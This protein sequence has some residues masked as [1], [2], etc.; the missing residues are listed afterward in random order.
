MD[1]NFKSTK[2]SKIVMKYEP[3]GVK[4]SDPKAFE[5]YLKKV[6]DFIQVDDKAKPRVL[7]EEKPKIAGLETADDEAEETEDKPKKF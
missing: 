4:I 7:K 5:G 1:F 2:G 3:E 6:V